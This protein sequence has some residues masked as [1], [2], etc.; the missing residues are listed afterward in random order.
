[1]TRQEFRAAYRAYR[2]A[3][4]LWRFM[5]PAAV[6][7]VPTFVKSSPK[8]DACRLWPDHL[9]VFPHLRRDDIQGHR[10]TH[11]VRMARIADRV[12]L[13]A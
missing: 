6:M 4:T 7:P 12:R 5:D 13:P 10:D 8:G 2:T 9:G 1:M 3:A 11:R